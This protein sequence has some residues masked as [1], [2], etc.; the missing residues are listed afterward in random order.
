MNAKNTKRQNAHI[1]KADTVKHYDQLEGSR[2]R[3]A[4]G[5]FKKKPFYMVA[6]GKER[7]HV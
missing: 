6:A 2:N 1:L 7:K 4:Y 3:A 5:R